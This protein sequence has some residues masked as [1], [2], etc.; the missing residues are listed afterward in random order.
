MQ[1][2]VGDHAVVHHHHDT[3]C[4]ADNQ[5]HAKQIP[6]TVNEGTGEGFFTHAGNHADDNGRTQ[7]DC[8]YFCHPPSEYRDAINHYRKGGG[9]YQQDPLTRGCEFK[10]GIAAIAEKMR[11][12]FLHFIRHNRQLRVIADFARIT[13]DPHHTDNIADDQQQNA[14]QHSLG[15]GDPGGVSRDNRCERVD[16]RA[17][18]ANAR[19]EQ[20]SGGGN[21]RIKACGHHDRNQQCV[22]WE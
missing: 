15:E 19:A 13:H 6:R 14:H 7:K 21:Q 1:N 2:S 8:G 4:N 3:A 11:T 10:I 18:C 12:V 5:R 22:E 9:E 17:E 20:N 16:C